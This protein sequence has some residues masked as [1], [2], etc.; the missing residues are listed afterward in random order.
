MA[1]RDVARLDS[2]KFQWNSLVVQHRNQP[3]HRPHEPLCRLAPIHVLR[4]IDRRNFLGKIFGQNVGRAPAFFGD[5]RGQIF[6]LGRADLLQSR[7]VHA[8]LSGKGMS[9]R[10][11]FTILIGD[12]HRRS[13]DLLRC[14]RL[15]RRNSLSHR[16]QSPRRIEMD[17]FA[18]RQAFPDQQSGD[19]LAQFLRGRVDHPRRNL[20][21]TDLK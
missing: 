8:S 14:V 3:A 13:G 6:A 4:P 18:G 5:F 16:R 1:A 9:C 21:A 17:D 7:Y 20:F 11:W 10:G 12:I 15:G 19:A 2:V